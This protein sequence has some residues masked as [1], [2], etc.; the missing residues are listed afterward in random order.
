MSVAAAV[1]R[2]DAATWMGD[3][4]E[5]W[6]VARLKYVAKLGT[7]HTPSRKVPD[8]WVPEECT[9][10][11]VTLGDVWQLRD[12][13]R[14]TTIADTEE[15]I[16]QIG[17]AN[18]AAVLHP[19]GT[20]ILSRTASV[21]F[22]AILGIDAATSQDFM[23]W[24]CGPRVVPM[25][26]LYV[27]RAMKQEFRRLVMGSTH[28]TIYMPDIERLTVPLPPVDEQNAIVH[29]IAA[30]TA[31]LDSL[32]EVKLRLRRL[33]LERRRAVVS[34]V[35]AGETSGA[36]ARR[37]KYCLL[38]LEQ[39]W[40]PQCESRPADD[41]EWGVLK[42]GCVNGR[43]FDANENKALP[44]ELEPRP[45]LEIRPGDIL[46]S[47][48]NTR[49]LLG[50]IALVGPDVRP[51]LLLSDKLYRL[52]PD[53]DIVEPEY[54]VAALQ[55]ASARAQLERDATGAS[56]SMQNISQ[57]TVRDVR[58]PVP[59][60]AEQRRV[61]KRL[62]EQTHVLDRLDARLDVQLGLLTEHRETLIFNAVTGRLQE[63]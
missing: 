45:E 3:I 9:I 51:K 6:D 35:V 53:R 43:V 31:E 5:H 11:W 19:K 38:G 61:I 36:A 47:R 56:A 17:L 25:Y 26:L 13:G 54:L 23:T 55:S 7:G 30:S 40:S 37:M 39:G 18:S 58:L 63:E 27:L 14:T 15:K 52:T 57:R 28:K 34:A 20:V 21:G 1:E 44:E 49:E 2:A 8:Y 59:T 60:V 12:G 48:A 62:K 46:M 32:V 29:A 33:L 50:S 41:A 42:V 4:P 24:T 16:S 22:S 10:P